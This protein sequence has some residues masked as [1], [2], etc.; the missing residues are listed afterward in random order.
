MIEV[1][2]R[3]QDMLLRL[4]PATQQFLGNVMEVLDTGQR[5]RFR[6]SLGGLGGQ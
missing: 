4:L 1:A 3:Y 6:E 5:A 2:G